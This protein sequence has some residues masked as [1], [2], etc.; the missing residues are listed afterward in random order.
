LTHPSLN[1]I[2]ITEEK[3][4]LDLLT[5][6]NVARSVY[7]LAHTRIV[8]NAWESGQE[9][10]IHGWCY[11]LK[12]GMIRDLKMCINGEDQLEDIYRKSDNP[13]G[14]LWFF[15]WRIDTY[16]SQQL[17]LPKRVFLHTKLLQAL[18]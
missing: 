2:A 8:Q 10:T 4:Q 18:F 17:Y 14:T 16:L 1:I 12:D 13:Q 5:E 7:N 9:L 11:K 6:L 15:F 3:K